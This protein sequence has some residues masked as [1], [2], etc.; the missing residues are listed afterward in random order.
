M[1]VKKSIK[2]GMIKEIAK[3]KKLSLITSALLI[4][5]SLAFAADTIDAAF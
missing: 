2:S 1:N 4:S 5:S 3:G